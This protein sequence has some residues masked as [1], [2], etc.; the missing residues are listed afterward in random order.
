MNKEIVHLVHLK[1]AKHIDVTKSTVTIKVSHYKIY[2]QLGRPLQD[3]VLH[4][5][6]LWL[7]EGPASAVGFAAGWGTRPL[8]APPVA[9]VPVWVGADTAAARITATCLPP[10]SVLTNKGNLVL[11]FIKYGTVHLPTAS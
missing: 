4:W 9:P 2:L 11:L 7:R 6:C 5:L 10:H 3:E 8:P 1:K